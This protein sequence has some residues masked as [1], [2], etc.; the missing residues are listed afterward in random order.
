MEK[1]K[2]CIIIPVYHVEQYLE[3][4]LD[5]VVRQTYRN[6]EVILIHDRTEDR[7][8][9][10]CDTYASLDK[11]LQVV[12]REKADVS[13]AR[14]IG[15]G[16]CSGDYV[17]FLDADDWLEENFC[18]RLNH[19]IEEKG[20][21]DLVLADAYYEGKKSEPKKL[22]NCDTHVFEGK[23][24][25][26]LLQLDVLSC[27]FRH[28]KI[29]GMD[30]EILC[31]V[32]GKAFHSNIAKSIDFRG[33]KC[34]DILYNLYAFQKSRQI[35]YLPEYLYHYRLNDASANVRYNIERKKE[36]S[37]FLQQ[38]RRFVQENG[39][40]GRFLEAIRIRSIWC[41]LAVINNTVSHPANRASFRQKRKMVK[42]LA[43]DGCFKDAWHS[44][45][46]VGL[47]GRARIVTWLMK[48]RLYGT[49][50]ALSNGYCFLRHIRT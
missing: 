21:V 18:E 8:G 15:L 1:L 16:M 11:R 29:Q 36:Y 24:E 26:E 4:C 12:H 42:E 31:P 20:L 23:E 35:V 30:S 17:I 7:S 6:L 3:R 44:G 2:Y 40:D 9:D 10:I 33:K 25:K 19:I 43:A 37:F 22:F 49:V 38:C 5:S 46:P 45:K 48:C 41:M 28:E 13:S 27:R 39:L 47:K 14:N 34:E 32:W 50:V